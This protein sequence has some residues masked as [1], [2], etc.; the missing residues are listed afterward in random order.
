[1]TRR[2]TPYVLAAFLG[3]G[4]LAATQAMSQEGKDP[5]APDMEEMMKA[6]EAVAAPGPQH[7]RLREAVGTWKTETKIW[8]GPGEPEVS[9]G[10]S[11][12]K[13]ILGGRYVVEQFAS[14]FMGKPFE[15][16]GVYGYD[17]V[18]KKYVTIWLDN[19]GTGIARS[20]GTRDE[21]AKTT[22]YFGEY[23]D[24]MKGPSKFKNVLREV[25]KDRQ[26]FEMYM[27]DS[28]GQ[29]QKSMEITY[30]RQGS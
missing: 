28:G 3:A 21:A 6:Y 30:T 13:T 8:M 23:V 16:M 11:E 12:F 15:G 25:S 9:T 20:E 29:E 22:T 24:P 19:S 17:N 7:A 18:T 1:M 27:I 5:A 4:L 10:T 2:I 26:V 14:T